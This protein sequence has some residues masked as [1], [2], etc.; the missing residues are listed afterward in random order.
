MNNT[1]MIVNNVSNSDRFENNMNING[2]LRHQQYQQ[3]SS[4]KFSSSSSSPSSSN[5]SSLEEHVLLNGVDAISLSDCNR[6]NTK[7]TVNVISLL[8]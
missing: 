3:Q 1:N 7:T 5:N 2:N 8:L 4:C 6:T